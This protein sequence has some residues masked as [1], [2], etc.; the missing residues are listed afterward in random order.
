[1]GGTAFGFT[2]KRM[3][4]D[5]YNEVCNTI[6]RQILCSNMMP[7]YI[8]ES[9]RNKDS[10][11]DVDILVDK[12]KFSFSD[13]YKRYH[14]EYK[15]FRWNNGIYSLLDLED[16]QIDIICTEPENLNIHLEYLNYND[17]GNF[18]GKLAHKLGL[19][20]GIDGLSVLVRAPENSSIKLGIINISKDINYIYKLLDIKLPD[21]INSVEDIFNAITNSKYFHKE[22][23][24][25][26][27]L[28]NKYRTRNKKRINYIKLLSYIDDNNIQNKSDSGR[29][30]RIDEVLDILDNPEITEKCK[31]LFQEHLDKRRFKVEVNGVNVGAI[32]GLKGKDLG[33]FMSHCSNNIDIDAGNIN[34]QIEELFINY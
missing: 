3:G 10:F 1:M 30:L 23:F 28:N 31:K 18:V 24:D 13:F 25:L 33:K 5:E 29:K 2:A 34:S 20:Y 15:D 12:S 16:R 8:P 6:S 4:V 27:K 19:K 21:E 26:G 7:G 32:T 11:G 14:D 17:L 22:F 9:Y